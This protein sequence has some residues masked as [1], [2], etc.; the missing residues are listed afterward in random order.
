[1]ADAL[2]HAGHYLYLTR[3]G[4]WLSGAK[5]QTVRQRRVALHVVEA[6]AEGRRR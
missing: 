5:A 4:Q 1:M 2:Q 6:K 3:L